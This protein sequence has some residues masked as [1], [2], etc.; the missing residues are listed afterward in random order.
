M[1]SSAPNRHRYFAGRVKQRD[2]KSETTGV[3]TIGQVTDDA[4]QR[5]EASNFVVARERIYNEPANNG[6]PPKKKPR[7]RKR[8]DN[9]QMLKISASE[10]GR[11]VEFDNRHSSHCATSLEHPSDQTVEDKLEHSNQIRKPVTDRRGVD[12]KGRRKR[13]GKC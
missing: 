6:M 5:N 12:Y 8:I 10:H 13:D 1:A 4:K 9:I 7:M 3:G 11:V 2:V